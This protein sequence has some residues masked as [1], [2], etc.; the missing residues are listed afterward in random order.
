MVSED[1][2]MVNYLIFLFWVP[3]SKCVFK[4]GMGE[5]A[6]ISYHNFFI[7]RFYH[8]YFILKKV[9]NQT[10]AGPQWLP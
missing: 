10:V 8:D 3:Q 4:I 6:K 7:S 5:M 2:I 1:T 9:E